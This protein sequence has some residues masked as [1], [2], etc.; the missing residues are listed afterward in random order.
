MKKIIALSFLLLFATGCGGKWCHPTKSASDFESD[1]WECSWGRGG[2]SNAMMFNM[3]E[4]RNCLK[5]RYGWYPC[6]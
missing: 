2:D 3:L 6:K 4:G 5:N 1:K